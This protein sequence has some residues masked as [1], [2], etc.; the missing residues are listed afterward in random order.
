[1]DKFKTIPAVDKLLLDPKIKSL[2]KEFNVEIVTFSI[3]KVL[4][5]YR[6]EIRKTGKIQSFENIVKNVISQTRNLFYGSIK[7]VINATGVIIHTNLGRAPFGEKLLSDTFN[8]LK[9]YCNLEF[10]LKTGKR[11]NRNFH[12]KEILRFI[13]GAEDVL[14]VNNNAAAVVL[15]LNSLALNKDVVISRSELIEIGGSFRMPDIM[16]S[17]GCNMVEV[18]STNKTHFKDFENAVNENTALIFKAHKSNYIIKGFTED[19]SLKELVALGKKHNI[20]VV[21]DMGCGLLKK[22]DIEAFKNEPDVKQALTQGIDLICFSGDKLLGGPQAGIIAGKKKFVEK[23]RNMPLMRALRVD[24]TTLALLENAC[25]YYI[26]GETVKQNNCIIKMLCT[27]IN[28]LKTK[29]ET[30]KDYLKKYN[31]NSKVVITKA[32][33]GGGTLPDETID[34]YSVVLKN[35]LKS[36][37]QSS[38]F[39]EKMY[40]DLLNTEKPL[41]GVLKQGELFFDVLTIFDDQLKT[42]ASMINEVYKNNTI[43]SHC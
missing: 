43:N 2:I 27:D 4:D 14:I 9:G 30:L 11:S 5:N 37:A 13:T 3:R 42:T 8:V 16:E 39:A 34:S 17:S 32:R 24:K 7:P 10:D 26:S 41:L 15:I 18:G 38:A 31:I 28:D 6:Y 23:L 36:N 22:Y 1:M 35:D 21:Y 25:R 12:L 33:C 19:V 29:A 40:I 20:P